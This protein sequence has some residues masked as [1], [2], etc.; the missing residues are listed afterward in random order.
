LYILIRPCIA[1]MPIRTV[2]AAMVAVTANAELHCVGRMAHEVLHSAREGDWVAVRPVPTRDHECTELGIPV[3]G[4]ESVCVGVNHDKTCKAAYLP[5][6]PLP[7]H[8]RCQSCFV[9][10]STDVFYDANISLHGVEQIGMGFRG[11]TMRSSIL[12][13]DDEGTNRPRKGSKHFGEKPIEFHLK[14]GKFDLDVKVAMPTEIYYDMSARQNGHGQIGTNVELI[15][16]DHYVMYE[17]GKGWSHRNDKVKFVVGSN[18]EA[19]YNVITNMTFG[20]KSNLQ[21]EF[22]QLAWYHMNV[23]SEVAVGGTSTGNSAVGSHNCLDMG[24]KLDVVHEAN[25]DVSLLNHNV[26]EHWGPHPLSH[27]DGPVVHKCKDFHPPEA[28]AI[29]VVV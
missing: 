22:G 5:V 16:G 24:L 3:H 8:G 28:E 13:E 11:T 27:H 4:D 10:A 21:V 25:I 15:M 2:V 17:K 20:I 18:R 26:T 12:I 19:D 1:A 29:A 9:G 14:L 23:A 6:I 7:L